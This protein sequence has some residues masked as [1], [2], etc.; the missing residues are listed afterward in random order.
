M[1][2]KHTEIIR[3]RTATLFGWLAAPILILALFALAAGSGCD[4]KSGGDESG[5]GSD[6]SDKPTTK[7]DD[8]HADEAKLSAAAI[9]KYGV[10]VEKVSKRLLIPTV[11]VPA[12]V[13]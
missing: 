6:K 9:Q 8:K 3:Q 7:K 1:T 12:R 13:S 11:S 10:R 2:L 4:K 5:K